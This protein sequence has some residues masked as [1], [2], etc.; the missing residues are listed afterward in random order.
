MEDNIYETIYLA[1]TGDPS[2]LR[3]LIERVRP[4]MLHRTKQFCKLNAF[5]RYDQ[6]DLM[7]ES[8]IC[9]YNALGTYRYDRK[10][11]FMTY[12]YDL[13][14]NRLKNIFRHSTSAKEAS[15]INVLFLHER[16]FGNWESDRELIDLL[17]QKDDLCK[18]EYVLQMNE[19]YEMIL[20]TI[21]KMTYKQ[22]QAVADW[23]LN[24]CKHPY[25]SKVTREQRRKQAMVYRVKRIIIEA[26]NSDEENE[27]FY[28]H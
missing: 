9:L 20:R 17:E 23:A 19:A 5:L 21:E 24:A 3:I 13:F 7:Q 14:D 15:M 18:P 12:A 27:H 28:G 4:E 10:T 22:K 6:E 16:S 2:A 25:G 8:M 1:R 26:L 11:S